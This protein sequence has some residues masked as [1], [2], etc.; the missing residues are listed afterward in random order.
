[1][2]PRTEKGTYQPTP[3]THTPFAHAQCFFFP[4]GIFFFGV[5]PKNWRYLVIWPKNEREAGE[6]GKR[7]I[8]FAEFVFFSRSKKT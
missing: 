7:R 1:M 8:F 2:P 3:H 4:T 6:E 5:P